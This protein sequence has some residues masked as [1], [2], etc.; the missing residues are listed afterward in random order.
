MTTA[1]I[2]IEP[3]RP[4]SRRTTTRQPAVAAPAILAAVR[5]RFDPGLSRLLMPIALIL[6][7]RRNIGVPA[8]IV[9]TSY[10]SRW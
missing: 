1:E 8:R 2:S 9:V 6:R 5:R 3:N 7:A 10:V 4:L